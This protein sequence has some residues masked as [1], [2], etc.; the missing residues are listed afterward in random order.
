[1]TLI[2]FLAFKWQMSQLGNVFLLMPPTHAVLFFA[3]AAS[4]EISDES[5]VF[6][7]SLVG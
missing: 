1:M 2:L 7:D 5:F 6:S 3:L 4:V